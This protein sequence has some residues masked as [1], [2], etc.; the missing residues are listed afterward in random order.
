M[1]DFVNALKSIAEPTRLRI[2][3]ILLTQELTVSE[4]TEVLNYSQPR[5]SR[6]LKL[7]CDA[8]VLDRV[9]EGAWVFYRVSANQTEGKLARS[10]ASL[11]PES[12]AI[13]ERDMM[14]L[15]DVRKNYA[16]KAQDFFEQNAETWNDVRSLY[17]ASDKV[18]KALLE[19]VRNQKFDNLL[20]LGTGTGKMLELLGPFVNNAMGIDNSQQMLSVARSMLAEN[21]LNHCQV[22]LGDIFD[23]NLPSEMRFDAIT[24]HY[25]L[26]YLNDP[27]MLL[28]QATKL[29]SDNG[30]I[31][32][33]DFASHEVEM[34]REKFNH[35]RLGFS[36][37]EMA[38]WASTNKLAID[39][40]E[41]VTS[42]EVDNKHIDIQL[43]VLSAK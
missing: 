6:H 37:K 18:D 7:M 27:Q 10:I 3:N 17:F 38:D 15:R 40:Q 42:I 24:I 22:R 32:I 34:L 20:D 23:M 26:H 8:G 41:V 11:M 16:R 31:V 43:T 33:V 21:K 25:V 9:Q 30:K 4:I 12:T 29:L 35:R 1:E 5:I 14:R 28:S 13:T 36:N 2:L 39:S 19:F